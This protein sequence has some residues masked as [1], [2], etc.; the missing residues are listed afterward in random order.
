MS[1]ITSK[2]PRS[3]IT[4]L[5][6]FLG[7]PALLLTFSVLNALEAEDNAFVVQEREFQLAGLMRRL[8]AP[9]KDGKPLDLSQIYLAAGTSTLAS[10]TLQKLVVQSVAKASG[11]IVETTSLDVAQDEAEPANQ[12]VGIRA[13]FDIDNDGLL[14]LLHGLET[15]L[16]LVFVDKVSVRRLPGDGN[17]KD[18]SIMLRADIEA[19]ARWKASA[20]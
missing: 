12:T 15:G 19:K 16:P 3:R 11:K 5:L 8:T 9:A 14:T 20:P 2:T 18:T 4:G 7:A 6:L 1:A 17:G 13:S 10:A